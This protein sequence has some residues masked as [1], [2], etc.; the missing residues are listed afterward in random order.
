MKGFTFPYGSKDIFV[1]TD[2]KNKTKKLAKQ[3]CWKMGIPD[4]RADE[5]LCWLRKAECDVHTLNN[6]KQY[7]EIHGNGFGGRGSFIDDGLTEIV[8]I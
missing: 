2:K 1:A 6:G 5:L 8:Y 4:G 3:I 7:Y